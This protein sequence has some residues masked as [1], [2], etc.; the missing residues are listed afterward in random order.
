M[1]AIY[2]KYATMDENEYQKMTPNA[3]IDQAFHLLK[4]I[5]E[6][7]LFEAKSVEETSIHHPKGAFHGAAEWYRINAGTEMPRKPWPLAKEE[8]PTNVIE[9]LIF[10]QDV[11]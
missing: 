8:E 10:G 9:Q 2:T 3:I 1:F 5:K 4:K 7:N 6:Y 11:G